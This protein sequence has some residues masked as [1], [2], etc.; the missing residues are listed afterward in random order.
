[1]RSICARVTLAVRL[2]GGRLTQGRQL[3]VVAL[4]LPSFGAT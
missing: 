2:L 4:A 1:M 3:D